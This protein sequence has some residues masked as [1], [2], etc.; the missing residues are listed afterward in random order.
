MLTDLQVESRQLKLDH[1]NFLPHPHAFAMYILPSKLP[2]K[3]IVTDRIELR[4]QF[5]GILLI[6]FA[7][8]VEKFGGLLFHICI[9]HDCLHLTCTIRTDDSQLHGENNSLRPLAYSIP[10]NFATRVSRHNFQLALQIIGQ[11]Q[12]HGTLS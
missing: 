6:F 7:D 3:G 9:G 4:C 10:T 2:R 8:L 11:K 12:K 5:F 1:S